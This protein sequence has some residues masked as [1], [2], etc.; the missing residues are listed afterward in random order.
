MRSIGTIRTAAKV[1]IATA[2]AATFMFAGTHLHAQTIR[3]GPPGPHLPARPPGWSPPATLSAP[4]LTGFQVHT[5]VAVGPRDTLAAWEDLPSGFIQVSTRSGSG[6]WAPAVNVSDPKDIYSLEPRIATGPTGDAAIIFTGF[7]QQEGPPS[8]RQAVVKVVTRPA[9]TGTWSA[10]VAV[11]TTNF[12]LGG[13]P[14]I[15]LDA[16]GNTVAVWRGAGGAIQA[17]SRPA[18]G[19]WSH[20]VDI[21]NPAQGDAAYPQLALNPNGLAVAVWQMT[22]TAGNLQLAQASS[23]GPRGSWTAPVDLSPHSAQA[24]LPRVAVDLN[25]RAVAV[26]NQGNAIFTATRGTSGR[27][28][29]AMALSPIDPPIY[30]SPDIAMS[31]EGDAIVAW[32]AVDNMSG[33]SRIQVSTGGPGRAWSASVVVSAVDED[34]SDPHVAVDPAGDLKVVAWI[35]SGLNT[36]AS[37]SARVVT[38][39]G[40]TSWTA[41]LST[42][43]AI[44]GGMPDTEAQAAAG[45]GAR[46]GLIWTSPIGFE[47]MTVI[48]ASVFGR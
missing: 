8:I 46:A 34:V 12:F 3:R 5:A 23:K 27:W 13:S 2:L 32:S 18:G 24:W 39:T 40:R 6:R 10:P 21:S 36:G 19:A 43:G 16:N 4:G 33:Q 30:G 26:W 15:A 22:D 44:S 7:F 38:M 35:D 45:P 25:G 28:N 9:G 42:G 37:S 48:Q 14:Q 17:A 47:G 11:G 41:P 31:L 29:A 1:G 20:P